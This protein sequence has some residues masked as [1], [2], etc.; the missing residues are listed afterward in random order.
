MAL[1]RTQ[2]SH[3]YWE[4]PV[5]LRIPQPHLLTLPVTS[6]TTISTTQATLQHLGYLQHPT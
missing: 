5:F 1:A 4:M 3:M 6:L 2:Q